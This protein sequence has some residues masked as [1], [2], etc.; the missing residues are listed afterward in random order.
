MSIYF[1]LEDDSS[2]I[3][4]CAMQS[5]FDRISV[6]Q[7]GGGMGGGKIILFFGLNNGNE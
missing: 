1:L 3:P 4:H 7:Q 5:G 2:N 6:E